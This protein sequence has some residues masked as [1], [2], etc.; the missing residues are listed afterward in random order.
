MRSMETPIYY[1]SPI[2]WYRGRQMQIMT[3]RLLIA[4]AI[5][6]SA[7]W[8]YRLVE[9]IAFLLEQRQW[10]QYT[11]PADKIVLAAGPSAA[12]PLAG[13]PGYHGF[14][15]GGQLLAPVVACDTPRD[16]QLQSFES[17]CPLVFLHHLRVPGHHERLVSVIVAQSLSITPGYEC[18]LLAYAQIPA[19]LRPGAQPMFCSS[20]TAS[21]ERKL[22][23]VQSLRLFA[24]QPDVADESHFTI[25]YEIDGKSNTI[26]GW[27]MPDDSI[28]LEPR[29]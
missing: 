1:A 24:G 2:P 7:A 18:N 8:A 27:M 14:N 11:M 22:S 20:S 28:R 9:Q 4:G 16:L 13:A 21:G 12:G 5:A 19:N 29:H 3:I 26:D 10:M 25:R 15:L 23:A 6:C 17:Q